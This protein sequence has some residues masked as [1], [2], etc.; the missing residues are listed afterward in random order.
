MKIPDSACVLKLAYREEEFRFIAT[1]YTDDI[2]KGH[3]LWTETEK[4]RLQALLRQEDEDEEWYLD[5]DGERLEDDALFE[6]SPW[7][8]IDGNRRGKA[9]QRF[10]DLRSGESWFCLTGWVRIP[11]DFDF[12]PLD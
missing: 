8:V 12:H 7:S 4:A 2:L 11:W 3:F 10:L 5:D 9:V 6:K 1:E